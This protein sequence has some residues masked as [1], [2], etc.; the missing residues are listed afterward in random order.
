MKPLAE[1]SVRFAC[2]VITRAKKTGWGT[3][4]ADRVT[5]RL[6][7]T[8]VGGKANI[9]LRKFIA[10]AFETSLSAV[11]IEQGTNSR[12]KLIRV[13]NPGKVPANVPS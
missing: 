3:P 11:Q 1:N 7:A 12:L 4:S 13:D 10:D 9:A 6:N 5:V 8:P 2:K